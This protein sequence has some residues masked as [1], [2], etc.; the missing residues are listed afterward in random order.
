MAFIDRIKSVDSR[1]TSIIGVRLIELAAIVAV[2]HSAKSMWFG[3]VYD[4]P[5]WIDVAWLA[6]GLFVLLK[7]LITHLLSAGRDSVEAMVSV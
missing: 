2:G 3:R 5:D 6:W 1:A 7:S 4:R